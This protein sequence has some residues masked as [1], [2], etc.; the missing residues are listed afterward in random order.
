M[1]LMKT[2]RFSQFRG[3]GIQV[4]NA[5]QLH[6]KCAEESHTVSALILLFV[7]WKTCSNT[8]NIWEKR[9]RLVCVLC[10]HIKNKGIINNKGNSCLVKS[11]C[12]V[13]DY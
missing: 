11:R 6:C 9:G 5:F 12:W 2:D 3:L 4:S 10:S 1:V 7:L 8:C 13:G